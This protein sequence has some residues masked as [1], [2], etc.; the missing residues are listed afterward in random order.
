M[1]TL[2]PSGLA[3]TLPPAP[4]ERA[5]RALWFALA[6]VAL[7]MCAVGALQLAHAQSARLF[8]HDNDSAAALLFARVAFGF[9]LAVQ[10]A[11][12]N[13]VAATWKWRQQR[14]TAGA[15]IAVAAAWLAGV[16]W[17]TLR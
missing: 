9:S 1:T 2:P 5:R 14:S 3:P 12:L 15:A 7:L 6:A 16:C 8:A 13:D 4:W 10:I 17:L 11:A